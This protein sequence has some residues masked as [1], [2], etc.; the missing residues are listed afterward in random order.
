MKT[1][2]TVSKKDRTPCEVFSRIVGY[3]RPIDNWNDGK[4]AEFAMRQEYTV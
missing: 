3:I 2:K 4:A 1:K